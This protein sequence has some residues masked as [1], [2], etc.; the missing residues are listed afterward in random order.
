MPC[1]ASLPS[2]SRHAAL[3]LAI[4]LAAALPFNLSEAAKPNSGPAPFGQN[5]AQYVLTLA[6][7]FNTLNTALW[8]DHLWYEDD[9]P[10]V[11]YKV[12]NGTLK[13]WP[14]RDASGE[15]FNR[16]L[17]TDGKF[18][19]RYGYVEVEAR[20]PMGKGVWGG[21][22]MLNHDIP[23]YPLK[24][25]EVDSVEVY[26]GAG[27]N[28]GWSDASYRPIAYSSTVW[29]DQGVRAGSKTVVPGFDLSSGFHKYGF[30][31]EGTRQTFY[32]DGR[33]VYQLNVAMPD[34]MYLI[35]NL[36]FGGPAGEPDASTPTG[37]SNA[38]EVNYV[39][40]WRFK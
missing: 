29:T 19:Q 4:A 32:L 21:F 38:L 5:G 9:S 20:M 8:N 28:S 7:E 36:W 15:F 2:T 17:D 39:R 13:I 31:W 30:K 10:T 27:P 11:N 3:C 6:E 37:P 18:Y 40:T 16:S 22:W 23:A 35:L 34:P 33:Q 1:T 14:Q 12:E 26:P 25:P 24:R